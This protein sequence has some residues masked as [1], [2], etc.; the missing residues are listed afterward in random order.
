MVAPFLYS[1]ADNLIQ[2]EDY[3]LQ[4]PANYAP[5]GYMDGEKLNIL[6]LFHPIGKTNKARYQI[7]P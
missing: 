7:G 6:E 5:I 1:K 3:I 4:K 2:Y